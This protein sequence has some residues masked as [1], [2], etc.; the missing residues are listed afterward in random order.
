MRFYPELGSL[1]RDKG[2]VVQELSNYTTKKNQIMLQALIYLIQLLKKDFI[3]FKDEVDKLDYN[4]LVNVATSLNNLK[5][6]V[7]NLDVGKSKIFRNK[8]IQ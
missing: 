2:K 1:I 3:T 5:T 7:G 4:K 8:N 6:K